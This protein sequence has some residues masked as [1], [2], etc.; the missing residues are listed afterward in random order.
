MDGPEKFLLTELP[1]IDAFCSSLTEASTSTTEYERAQYVWQEFGIKSRREYH[2]H[3]LN[4]DVLL[5]AY[6]FE[7]FE[8]RALPLTV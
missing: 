6:I 5:L 3:Y 2:D 1:P 4:L 8:R 7:N